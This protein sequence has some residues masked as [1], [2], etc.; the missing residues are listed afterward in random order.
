MIRRRPSYRRLPE[1]QMPLTAL[2]DIVFLL[3]IYFLLT[4]NFLTQEGI[5]IKLPRAHS[6]SPQLDRPVTIFVDQSG[7]LFW[8]KEPVTE[9][10]LLERLKRALS[11]SPD[12]A[13]IIKA[14]RDVLLERAVKAMDLA[15]AA[16]ARRLL[17]ATERPR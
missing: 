12:R 13:V 14:D 15:R 3:L 16:G 17:L 9:A 1:I 6:S 5:N 7:R 8:K 10:E 4:A 11:R 2:I